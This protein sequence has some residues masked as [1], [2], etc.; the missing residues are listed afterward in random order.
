MK[1]RDMGFG[2]GIFVVPVKSRTYKGQNIFDIFSTQGLWGKEIDC[3]IVVLSG[4]HG[5]YCVSR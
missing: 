4:I 2:T 5:C 3:E 1:T